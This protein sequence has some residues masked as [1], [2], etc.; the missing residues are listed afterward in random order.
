MIKRTMRE[1]RK[2]SDSILPF[3]NFK[4]EVASECQENEKH[5]NEYWKV[6]ESGD[7]DQ[8]N[9]EDEDEWLWCQDEKEYSRIWP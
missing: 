3:I 1:V 5:C 7:I 9:E 4:E 8:P 2:L 6:Q